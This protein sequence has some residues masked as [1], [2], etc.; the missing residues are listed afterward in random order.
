MCSDSLVILIVNL[1]CILPRCLQDFVLVFEAFDGVR[2][3]CFDQNLCPS[4]R[5]RII[6]FGNLYCDLKTFEIIP[7]IHILCDH[8]AEFCARKGRAL[9]FF[10]E[11]ASEYV[12]KDYREIWQ[13]YKV[14]SEDHPQ[15][16][17][18]F[19]NSVLDLNQR[20]L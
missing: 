16:N 15:L 17:E 14:L 12:H 20:H 19:L 8:V 3:A 4:Y 13:H 6:H 10:N 7:K 11:H 5:N 2:H 1:L 9:G 18:Q